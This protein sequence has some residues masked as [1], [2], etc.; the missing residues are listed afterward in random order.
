MFKKFCSAR[1][2]RSD[3]TRA[4]QQWPTPSTA[5]AG[6]GI[7]GVGDAPVAFLKPYHAELWGTSVLK[8]FKSR[9]WISQDEGSW[10]LLF[11]FLF[12]FKFLEFKIVRVFLSVW[13]NLFF[14]YLTGFVWTM[15]WVCAVISCLLPLPSSV[16]RVD[17]ISKPVEFLVDTVPEFVDDSQTSS[18]QSL[19][20]ESSQTHSRSPCLQIP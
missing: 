7:R 14:K 12:H 18:G 8:D 6:W 15:T 16:L 9:G 20:P 3:L 10:I 17:H 19:K 2:A 11:F 13:W 4:G 5:P 1:V